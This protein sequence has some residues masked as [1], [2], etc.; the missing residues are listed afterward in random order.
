MRYILPTV[1]KTY[2]GLSLGISWSPF[3]GMMPSDYPEILEEIKEYL[4]LFMLEAEHYFDQYM[5][6]PEE[7]HEGNVISMEEYLIKQTQDEVVEE[8]DPDQVS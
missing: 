1:A 7:K 3:K 8:V 6:Q 4:D 5:P 2:Q